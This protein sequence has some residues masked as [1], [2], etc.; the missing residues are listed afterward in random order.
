M[1]GTFS[2]VRPKGTAKTE[3]DRPAFKQR[4]TQE[5]GDAAIAW[6]EYGSPAELP[7]I[8]RR[9]QYDAAETNPTSW[10]ITCFFVDRDHRRSGVAYGALEGALGADRFGWR[11]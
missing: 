6:Y 8:D 4:L 5:E 10:R 11:R 3:Y 9:K 1:A 2:L 7:N